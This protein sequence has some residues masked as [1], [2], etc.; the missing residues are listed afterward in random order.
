M[1]VPSEGPVS[2]ALP[3][4]AG[5]SPAALCSAPPGRGDQSP[6][7]VLVWGGAWC[8]RVVGS[9]SDGPKALSIR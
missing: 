4:G 1:A 8:Q 7:R 5:L 6:T 3:G 9:T 2:G